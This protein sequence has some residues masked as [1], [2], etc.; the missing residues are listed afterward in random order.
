MY[1]T[2][3]QVTN[4]FHIFRSGLSQFGI[5]LILGEFGTVQSGPFVRD[6]SVQSYVGCVFRPI[7][8][9]QLLGSPEAGAISM[10]NSVYDIV[11]AP[12]DW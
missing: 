9:G 1:S 7:A 4:I 10:T 2:D 11:K 5:K 3:S 6:P 12:L 8:Q